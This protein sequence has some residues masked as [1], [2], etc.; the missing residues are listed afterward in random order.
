MKQQEHKSILIKNVFCGWKC[1]APRM[2][3]IKIKLLSWRDAHFRL[4]NCKKEHTTEISLKYWWTKEKSA[5]FWWFENWGIVLEIWQ[6][7]PHVRKE[8][9]SYTAFTLAGGTL[10][11]HLAYGVHTGQPGQGFLFSFSCLLADVVHLVGGHM[12][13]N[14]KAVQI[15]WSF[16]SSTNESV[17]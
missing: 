6:G 16:Y 17:T 2:F 9:T 13:R 15:S 11:I 5:A 8:W 12:E 1:E 10:N 4:S 14:F 3:W 7:A